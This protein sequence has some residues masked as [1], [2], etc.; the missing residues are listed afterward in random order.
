M[1]CRV[2]AGAR[3]NQEARGDA[4]EQHDLRGYGSLCRVAPE[5]ERQM[6]DL[7]QGPPPEAE[8]ARHLDAEIRHHAGQMRGAYD[9]PGNAR[10][11]RILQAHRRAQQGCLS[12]TYARVFRGRRIAEHREQKKQQGLGGQR[13]R[14]RARARRAQEPTLDDDAGYEGPR[15]KAQHQ[16]ERSDCCRILTGRRVV[17]EAPDV[18]GHM[19][20]KHSDQN[21]AAGVDEAAHERQ[22]PREPAI[23]AVG[24]GTSFTREQF[25]FPF[26][27]LDRGWPAASYQE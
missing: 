21:E 25:R 9:C 6:G 1:N 7:G 14:V 18:A 12:V 16:A 23:L 24:T 3:T 17:G 22:V 26:A 11:E 13:Q 20:T 5:D 4:A 19:R 27:R 2:G 8:P 15:E 10:N